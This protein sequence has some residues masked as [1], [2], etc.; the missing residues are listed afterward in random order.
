MHLY[1]RPAVLA[2]CK[3]CK[4]KVLP[5]VVC[6][7]CGYYKGREILSVLSKLT[8]KEKKHREKE[9]KLAEKQQK[10][11]SPVTMESLSKK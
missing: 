4:N 11:E 7:N 5:Y 10:T 2:L 1:I 3:K 6:K 9:I 8:K